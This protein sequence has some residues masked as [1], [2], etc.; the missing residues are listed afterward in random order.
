MGK[1]EKYAIYVYFDVAGMEPRP[2]PLRWL[3]P[4]AG[5]LYA[6]LPESDGLAERAIELLT[7]SAAG[8]IDEALASAFNDAVLSGYYSDFVDKEGWLQ[9]L[10][11]QAK[12]GIGKSTATEID[13]PDM[14]GAIASS[15]GVLVSTTDLG[16][17]IGIRKTQDPTI[18]AIAAA[19]FDEE[20]V[21]W[22]ALCFKA[23]MENV[24]PD[25][26]DEL[27]DVVARALAG[28]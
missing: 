1:D 7:E 25:L 26:Q 27:A 24:T 8:Y 6:Y 16:E 9:Q 21:R 18:R 5:Y 3:R 23:R 20:P 15:T 10:K 19:G 17:M 22:H 12:A 4:A 13:L 11:P 2:A 14:G 28:I